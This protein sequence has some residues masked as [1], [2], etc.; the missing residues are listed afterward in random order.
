[1]HLGPLRTDLLAFGPEIDAARSP[2]KPTLFHALYHLDA[3]HPDSIRCDSLRLHWIHP[4]VSERGS[5]RVSVAAGRL[6]QRDRRY[7]LRRRRRRRFFL[8]FAVS[9]PRWPD[10]DIDMVQTATATVPRREVR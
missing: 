4:R 5:E 9:Q 1:M 7:H 3:L 2:G 8:F 10:I 6:P